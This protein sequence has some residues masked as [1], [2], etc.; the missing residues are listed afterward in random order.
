MTSAFAFIPSFLDK[1]I[2][3]Y[4]FEWRFFNL[5]STAGWFKYKLNCLPV[6][7]PSQYEPYHVTIFSDCKIN[8]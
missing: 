5:T 1:T 2:V 3:H 4:C 7:Y 8:T 6:R